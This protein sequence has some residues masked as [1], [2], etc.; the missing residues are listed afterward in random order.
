VAGK[1]VNSGEL[2]VAGCEFRVEKEKRKR[3]FSLTLYL[4]VYYVND[5]F[6]SLHKGI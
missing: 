5:G 3:D 1:L 2:R 6:P 4:S